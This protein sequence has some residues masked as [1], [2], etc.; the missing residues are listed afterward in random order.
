[1]LKETVLKI[2]KGREREKEERE[3]ERER[4]RVKEHSKHLVSKGKERKGIRGRG[5]G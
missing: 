5:R 4:E 1:M 3:R 2:M